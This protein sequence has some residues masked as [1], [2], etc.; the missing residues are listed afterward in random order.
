MATTLFILATKIDDLN[1]HAVV[2]SMMW[3]CYWVMQGT[4]LTG[5]YFGLKEKIFI[6]Q[7]LKDYG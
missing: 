7:F 3:V 1:V 5:K 4:I 6:D 2:K